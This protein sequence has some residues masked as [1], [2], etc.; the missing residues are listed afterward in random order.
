MLIISYVSFV[1]NGHV[2]L[3]KV[4]QIPEHIEIPYE[5]VMILES[6]NMLIIS[7]VSLVYNIEFPTYWFYIGIRMVFEA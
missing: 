1:H 2:W 6:S 7:Y 5:N 3:A 4:D